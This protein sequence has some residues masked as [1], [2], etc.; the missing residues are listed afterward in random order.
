MSNKRVPI[1]AL[2][3]N[4]RTGKGTQLNLLHNSLE[5]DGYQPIILRGD[6]TRP[7]EGI[8]AGDPYSEWWKNFK[9]YEKSFENNFDAWRHG[10][11]LLMAEAA[12]QRSILPGNGV[13]LFDRAG[14]SR[15][16]MTLKEGL[17]LDFDNMYGQATDLENLSDEEILTL[18]PDLTIHLTAPAEV[19]LGRL[20]KND[21][22]LEFRATN[23]SKSNEYFE[24]AHR[25]YQELGYSEVISLDARKTVEDSA[26]TIY[27]ATIGTINSVKLRSTHDK[28]L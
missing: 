17:D 4:H 20:N 18:Q 24:Q 23:I 15:S 7:G 3:G 5:S 26:E 8:A 1:I 16:Q 19:L 28:H 14:I 6:G 13:I 12:I 2:D 10:A 11:R 21:P 27:Y 22:K 25:Q 9:N